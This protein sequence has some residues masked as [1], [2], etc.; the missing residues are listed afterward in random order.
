VTGTRVALTGTP[1]T[2]K[3][4][5]ARLLADPDA[6]E[7]DGRPPTNAASSPVDRPATAGAGVPVV[8]LNEAIEAAGL[9]AGT[10]QDRGSV[11]AD[12]DAV[13]D[14]LDEHAPAGDHV[15]ESH[16]AHRLPADRVVVL[17]C[18]PAVL[19]TRLVDRGE[20]P[21]SARENAES[22]ALDVILAEA[23]DRHG[24]DAVYEVDATDRSP[25]EVAEAV[26]AVLAGD[27]DPRSGTVD[28]TAY[29]E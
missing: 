20:S 21:A 3:T 5:A 13:D 11:Y 14:W 23:V 18:A 17:R 16:L 12:L 29:L 28:F 1:G 8:H 4:T 15:V 22:E 26:R 27:R 9:H 6:H 2:G 25:D 10:D 7:A 24:A 19:E